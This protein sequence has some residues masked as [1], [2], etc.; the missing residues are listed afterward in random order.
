WRLARRAGERPGSGRA[1]DLGLAVLALGVGVPPRRRVLDQTDHRV[2]AEERRVDAGHLELVPGLEAHVVARLDLVDGDGAPGVG[3]G[4]I[5]PPPQEAAHAPSEREGARVTA[6]PPALSVTG[7]D[8][9][10]GET[11]VL[12]GIDWVVQAHERWVI[13]GPNGSGKTS[14]LRLV[15]FHRG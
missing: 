10:E 2:H 6:L 15:S 3:H 13:V 12:R 8:L 4:A 9:T 1:P 7:V 11:A 5:L 14:L